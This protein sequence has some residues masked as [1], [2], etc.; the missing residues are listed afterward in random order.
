[1]REIVY[2]DVLVVLNLLVSYFL[3]LS[4]SYALKEK[5]RRLRLFLGALLGGLCSLVAFLPEMGVVFNVLLRIVSG[6]VIVL[7][8]FGFKTYRR[9]LKL[10]AVFVLVTF[11]F[12]GLMIGMWLVFRPDGMVINNSAVYFRI[13]LP[14]LV[15]STSVCYVVS[16]TAIKLLNKNKP[17]KMISNIR[18]EVSGCVLE[19]RAM[20]DTG[21]TLSEGFSGYPVVVCTYD[22]I[23]KAIPRDAEDFLK[24]DI[25]ALSKIT[26]EN[27][28]RRLR[29]VSFL[30]VGDTGLMPAFQPDRI[31]V[32]DSLETDRVFVGVINRKKHINESFD[33]L[34]NPNLF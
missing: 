9:F 1:M 18:L 20:L 24:G 30:T 8:T 10:F 19:G 32:D 15:A 28:R 22:F 6:A 16:K 3:L 33:M 26:D 5:A 34:L 29:V 11:L 23:R 12:A 2:V 21:N 7:V 4:T 14:L 25:N 13:S 27:W 31:V 17:Q